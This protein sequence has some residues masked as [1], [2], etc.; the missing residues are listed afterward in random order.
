MTVFEKL[1]L[2]EAYQK[3]L[4][5]SWGD[6]INAGLRTMANGS[7]VV[8]VP[9]RPGTNEL[10]SA[11]ELH[12]EQKNS[13]IGTA[14]GLA[15]GAA[16]V[17]PAAA[18]TVAKGALRGANV[19]RRHPIKT[20]LGMSGADAVANWWNGY[21]KNIDS[22]NLDYEIAKSKVEAERTGQSVEDVLNRNGV[23]DKAAKG[24][25]EKLTGMPY[26]TVTN[27]ANKMT[28]AQAYD[29]AKPEITTALAKQPLQQT[30]RD[31]I[32]SP[33]LRSAV[34][35]I[36]HGFPLTGPLY[37]GYN[38]YHALKR[39]NPDSSTLSN[40]GQ[41]AIKSL[42]IVRHLVEQPRLKPTTPPPA[43][44]SNDEFNDIEID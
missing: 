31:F 3:V 11:K 27:V 5:E 26:E 4:N 7:P 13:V 34:N 9:Y 25:I 20:L 21:N 33:K 40:L 32:D 37:D 2:Q 44:I 10:K 6:I 15:A 19:V 17:N 30:D 29:A 1:K 8:T 42:P 23:I 14:A 39:Q 22:V 36:G 28:V 35:Q 24:Q 16:A 38:N 12:Q 18:A 41:A 43:P